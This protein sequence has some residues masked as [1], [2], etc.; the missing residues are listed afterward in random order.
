L[1]VELGFTGPSETV[2]NSI[3]TSTVFKV[4]TCV[5]AGCPFVA[6]LT[7]TGQVVDNNVLADS[8]PGASAFVDDSFHLRFA[9]SIIE[10][11]YRL[12]LFE[13]TADSSE[14]DS[15]ELRLVDH[16][17]NV[18]LAAARD[19]TL[20]PYTQKLRLHSART[21]DGEEIGDLIATLADS[22]FYGYPDD[23][24]VLNFGAGAS[25]PGDLYLMSDLKQPTGVD[26]D[27]RAC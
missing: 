17:P 3:H 10:G 18:Q 16:P 2:F 22:N 23:E 6:I 26:A 24:V 20:Y 7:D 21:D 9:P 19:G 27:S 15:V 8:G 14:F 25:W 12:L 1:Q 11:E 4:K 13:T 5:G